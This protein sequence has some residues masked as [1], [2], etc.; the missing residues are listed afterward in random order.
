MAGKPKPVVGWGALNMALNG[1][2]K[3]GLI[4]SYK[5]VR[6]EKDAEVGVEVAI[7][8]GADQAEIVRRVREVLPEAF[9]GANVWTRAA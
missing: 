3:E 2:V 6:P 7:A 8:P 1:L 9:S 4:A 5:T